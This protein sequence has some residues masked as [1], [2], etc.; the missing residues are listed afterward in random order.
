M[1][2]GLFSFTLQCQQVYWTVTPCCKRGLAVSTYNWEHCHTKKNLNFLRKEK[3]E[4]E[5]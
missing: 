1:P 5:Y 4:N 2:P 3:W